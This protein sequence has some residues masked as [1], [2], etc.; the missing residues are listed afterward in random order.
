MPPQMGTIR[1]RAHAHRLAAANN[2][3]VI[4]LHAQWLAER[5]KGRRNADPPRAR[6]AG[7]R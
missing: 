5:R 7:Q 3:A 6:P 1:Q 4:A 2:R